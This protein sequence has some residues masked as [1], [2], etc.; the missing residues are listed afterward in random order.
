LESTFRPNL[1]LETRSR[2][3]GEEPRNEG[4]TLLTWLARVLGVPYRQPVLLAKMAE[5]LDR[6]SGGRLILGLGAGSGEREFQAMGLPDS[7]VRSRVDALEEAI[8]IVTS[9]WEKPGVTYEGERYVTRDAR[10]EPRPDHRVPIWLGTSGPRGLALV[11]KR[12][13]GWNPSLPYAPPDR[14]RQM[15]RQIRR[16]SEQISERLVDFVG[17]GF[18]GFNFQ[19]VGPAR[20][21]QIERIAHEVIPTVRA[22]V[23]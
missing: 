16:F 1:L 19:P 9:L 6:L 15:I 11:G 7:T 17:M 2:T 20:E 14:A 23:A 18:T 22:A 8:N 12:A 5:T 4:W 10:I 21:G 3:L 13:D